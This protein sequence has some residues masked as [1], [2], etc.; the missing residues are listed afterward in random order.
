VITSREADFEEL[1]ESIPH[2]VWMAAA[3]GHT[4][5][6]NRRGTDYTGLPADANF[7]WGWLEQ[8]HH[9]DVPRAKRAW[10][11]ATRTATPYQLEYR[12]RRLDGV[13]RWHDFRALPVR[14]PDGV[15]ERW[16]GTATD[17]DESMRLKG[18]VKSIQEQ[19]TDALALLET[20]QPEPEGFGFVE[21][22]IRDIRVNAL[23]AEEPFPPHPVADNCGGLSAAETEVVR[24]IALGYTNKEIANQLGVSLRTVETRRSRSL[25]KLGVSSRAELVGFAYR[26]GLV[27]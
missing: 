5:Y 9:L 17:I 27:G 15:V 7:G 19:A 11:E 6:F 21:Q 23:L 8:V 2:I 26:T 16:I 20:L 10:E 1:A 22:A 14:H 3:D 25:Q 18:R 4:N 12:L 13:F 24:L